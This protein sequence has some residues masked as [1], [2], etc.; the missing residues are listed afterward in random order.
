MNA[1]LKRQFEEAEQTEKVVEEL[2]KTQGREI[3]TVEA[4]DKGKG[5][6]FVKDSDG[7]KIFVHQSCIVSPGFRALVE[8][9]KISFVRGINRDKP[10]CEDVR[11]PDGTPINNEV[12]EVENSSLAKKRKQALKEQWKN[13]FDIPQYAVKGY[14]YSLPAQGYNE[15]AFVLGDPVPQLGKV[16]ALAH[17]CAASGRQ[18]NECSRFLEQKLAKFIAKNYEESSD[19]QTAAEVSITDIEKEWMERA[20]N[21]SLTDG[22]QAASALFV[23]ALNA[24]GQPC[25]QVYTINASACA[26]ILCSAEGHPVRITEPFET[27]KQRVSLEQAGY[28]VSESGKAEVAFAEA[29]QTRNV[30]YYKLPSM[31]IVGG[32]P[33]KTGKSPVVAKP[34]VKKVREWRCVA[35]E[36]LFML[37]CSAEV[38]SVMSDL[39]IMNAAMDAW[40]SN[41]EGLD[42]WEAAA[43]AV[44]RTA[45]SRGPETDTLACMAIQFWWQ[46]KPLQRLLARREDRKKSGAPAT[47]GPKPVEKDEFDMF[48]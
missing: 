35:G 7:E 8:D 45:Q 17:G 25:V 13:F 29:N 34:D 43:K 38:L 40:A 15:D 23:H 47:A 2:K 33:F 14:G 19:A 22:C 41:A 31:R 10:W 9:Q 16:F 27:K 3:G 20:K 24:A 18:G 6:G 42:G 48:G 26:I 11:N 4:Y 12:P 32:R 37:V 1:A 28:N 39:D 21:K 5:F 44:V 36:E 30:T 46:E